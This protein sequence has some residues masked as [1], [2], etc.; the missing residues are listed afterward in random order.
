M[1]TSN[2]VTKNDLKKVLQSIAVKVNQDCPV[3]HKN[4][5]WTNDSPTTNFGETTLTISNLSDYDE[6]EVVWIYNTSMPTTIGGIMRI[7]IG[8][9]GILTEIGSTASYNAG[10]IV[11]VTRICTVNTGSVYFGRANLAYNGD[12]AVGYDHNLIPYKIYGIKSATANMTLEQLGIHASTRE[13]T[14]ADG[15]D[16]DIWI[17]YSA[18]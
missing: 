15:D 12:Y 1:S 6:V 4:L 7:P 2:T 18:S 14:S 8:F 13:P 11:N 16:G 17:K 10:A 5:L 9:N 3:G